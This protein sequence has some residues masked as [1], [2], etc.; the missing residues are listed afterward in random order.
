MGNIFQDKIGFK[1]RHIVIASLLVKN[2]V[3]RFDWNNSETIFR[4][5]IR[6]CS[7]RSY[8]VK[9]EQFD[10]WIWVHEKK[11]MNFMDYHLSWIVHKQKHSWI[12]IILNKSGIVQFYLHY[13]FIKCLIKISFRIIFINHS[14]VY[15]H[16]L[17]TDMHIL[18]YYILCIKI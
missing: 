18:T 14:S 13:F 11:L 12:F 8:E 2:D 5:L 3:S 6:K 7:W 16:E 4:N 9:I 15:E 17:C 10:S 1:T